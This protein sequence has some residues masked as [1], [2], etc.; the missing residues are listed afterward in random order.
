[1]PGVLR[2]HKQPEPEIISDLDDDQKRVRIVSV[3][4]R[5][6][7]MMRL[8]CD[9]LNLLQKG[10]TPTSAALKLATFD[11]PTFDDSLVYKVPE[12]L[13]TVKAPPTPRMKAVQPWISDPKRDLINP[14]RSW[15]LKNGSDDLEKQ[16]PTH[17]P[18][19][20]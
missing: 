12:K 14:W 3:I 9:P 1:M 15:S 10:R 19:H 16:K 2:A 18:Y 4:L 5:N 8:V 20:R 6:L 13:S 7:S 17:H 11:N